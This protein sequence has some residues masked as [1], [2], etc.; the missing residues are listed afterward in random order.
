M[1]YRGH[2]KV[3]PWAVNDVIEVIRGKAYPLMDEN[4]VPVP[5]PFEIEADDEYELAIKVR[6]LQEEINSNYHCDAEI[7]RP[8]PVAP[9]AERMSELKLRGRRRR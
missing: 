6:D 3:P 7:E 9:V 8:L 2:V 5:V 1:K 4:E